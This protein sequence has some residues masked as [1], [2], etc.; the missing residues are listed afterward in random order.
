MWH[1]NDILKD[2]WHEKY[3]VGGQLCPILRFIINTPIYRTQCTQAAN[4]TLC[5]ARRTRSIGGSSEEAR[6]RS[7]AAAVRYMGVLVIC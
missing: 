2:V 4:K 1:W 3:G 6:S 5:T 7:R